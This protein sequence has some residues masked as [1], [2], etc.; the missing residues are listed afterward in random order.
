MKRSSIPSVIPFP[1][2]PEFR[3]LM[4]DNPYEKE[5]QHIRLKVAP[6]QTTPVRI[7][8]Y[9]TEMVQNA[10][11]N[12]VQQAITEKRVLV[13]GK[14]TKASYLV[15]PNDFIEVEILKPKKPEL[16]AESIPLDII[17]EDEH[18]LVINKPADM[19]VHPAFGNWS[20]TMVNAL[21][22]H[23]GKLSGVA[24]E[25][26]RPGIVHRID[27]GTSGLL[28]VA[29][30]DV[31]H[32]KLSRQ[33][34]KHSIERTYHAIVW[35]H[36]PDEGTYDG[37][38]GRSPK[39]RKKMAVLEDERAKKAITHFRVIERFDHLSMVEIS[40]ETG[41]THQIRVHF[42]HANHPL[43]ADPVYGGDS[44][45]YGPNTGFRKYLFTK[46]F[47]DL[48]RQCLHA[49]S[50]GFMHPAT[51]EFVHFESELP[52]DFEAAVEALREYCV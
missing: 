27:K 4:A 16:T 2:K 34:Y 21:L 48:G 43:L 10:T 23:V 1:E 52:P 20:G 31:T 14:P 29:R 11:R 46:L 22:H 32:N 6:G 51:K 3:G 5:V 41:R 18:L 24:E 15:Q 26:M 30:D 9:L 38:L 17:Y 12:K 19:V 45:R 7:D 28:V 37:R 44:V 13:N 39:D 25:A 49:R 50:L 42:S 8:R 35:G 40:L 33:F 36:P 47:E